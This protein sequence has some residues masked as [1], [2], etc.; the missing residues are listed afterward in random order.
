MFSLKLSPLAERS[1]NIQS[2][3]KRFSRPY[4]SGSVFNLGVS[5]LVVRGWALLI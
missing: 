1:I 3:D 5:W 2:S 4:L